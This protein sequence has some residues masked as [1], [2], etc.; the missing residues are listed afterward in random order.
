MG[1]KI[2]PALLVGCISMTI[3]IASIE[4]THAYSDCTPGA[5]PL[6]AM[7]S[8]HPGDSTQPCEGSETWISWPSSS[9]AAVVD[10]DVTAAN[11]EVDVQAWDLY[12]APNELLLP[13]A[14]TTRLRISNSGFAVH[15]LTVDEL[16]IELV[17]GRGG[18]DEVTLVGPPPGTYT[19]Y[20]SVS[21]H[22]EAGMEGIL[23]VE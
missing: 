17:V 2:V 18:S 20:C 10:A 7:T 12:F 5:S 1:P 16:A 14:G 11:V 22:R 9:P 8:P 4:A 3:G 13:A 23:I 6:A 19:F 15:N 21:G